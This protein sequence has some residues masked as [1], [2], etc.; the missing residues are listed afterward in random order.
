MKNL[1]VAL[2]LFGTTALVAAALPACGVVEAPYEI[3]DFSSDMAQT[4]CAWIYGDANAQQ[5]ACCDTAEQGTLPGQGNYAACVTDK[6]SEYET[7]L[8]HVVPESWNGGAAKQCVETVKALATTCTRSFALTAET[9]IRTDCNL[10]T[11]TKNAGDACTDNWDCQTTFCRSGTCANPIPNGD[12]CKAGE[13]CAGAAQCI[14]DVCRA[15]QPNDAACT[16]S[17][18]CMSGSCDGTQCVSSSVFMCD[19]Q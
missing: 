15:L 1:A 17:Y 13:L 3:N 8:A 2:G 9:K 7:L 4:Y 16:H 5:S 14:N 10:V 6:S 12:A 18:E 19:G 11:P